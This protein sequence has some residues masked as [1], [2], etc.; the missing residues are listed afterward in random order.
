[1]A[2]KSDASTFSI[3]IPKSKMEQQ[4]LDRLSKLSKQRDLSIN[5]LVVEAILEYLD[6][7][8]RREARTG[9]PPVSLDEDEG[10]LGAGPKS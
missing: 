8:E 10:A 1:M 3:F 5:Y 7:A 2:I 9:E 4:P 6:H